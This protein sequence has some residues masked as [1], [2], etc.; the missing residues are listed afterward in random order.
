MNGMARWWVSA[1]LWSLLGCGP[2]D[3]RAPVEVED[4]AGVLEAGALAPADAQAEAAPADASIPTCVGQDPFSQL[5]CGLIPA[6]GAQ[7]DTAA[8]S[9][10]IEAFG[11]LGGLLGGTQPGSAQPGSAQ[12]GLGA[13]D[14]GRGTGSFG[15]ITL[16]SAADCERP[17]DQR[18]EL[19]CGL[20][21]DGGFR[22][23]TPREA[24]VSMQPADDAGDPGDG[25]SAADAAQDEEAPDAGAELSVDGATAS[26]ADLANDA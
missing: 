15:G 12:P 7:G 8:L 11:G 16:P 24:G 10:I 13:R 17:A 5:I 9:D 14:G 4:D 25:G 3:E 21:R 19:L 20:R 2:D 22:G 6:N 1:A 18:T 26:D 23:R